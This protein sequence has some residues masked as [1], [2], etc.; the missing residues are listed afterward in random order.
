MYAHYTIQYEDEPQRKQN[1]KYVLSVGSIRSLRRYSKA[2]E[3][4]KN[5]KK[6]TTRQ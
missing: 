5:K 3:G 1:T 2:I 6:N 4:S